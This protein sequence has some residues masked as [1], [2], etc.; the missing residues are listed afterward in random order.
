MAVGG[1]KEKLIAADRFGMSKVLIPFSNR[2]DI[3][4]LPESVKKRLEI[5]PV[6]TIE[7]VILHTMG[8]V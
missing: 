6:K 4:E 8:K 5:V 1:I 2:F 7:E 3:E